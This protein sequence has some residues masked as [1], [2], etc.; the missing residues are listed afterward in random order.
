MLRPFSSKIR[1]RYLIC[2]LDK[3]RREKHEQFTQREDL[4]Q[5]PLQ[6]KLAKA[7]NCMGSQQ[8]PIELEE[9]HLYNYLHMMKEVKF[10]RTVEGLI[11]YKNAIQW[12][13]I[14]D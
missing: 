5:R 12:L 3:G 7:V 10:E 14:G 8:S 2:A 9:A 6:I 13:E 4:M 1:R 11:K